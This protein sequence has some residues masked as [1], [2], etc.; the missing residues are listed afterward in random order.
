MSLAD[1]PGAVRNP[2][3]SVPSAYDW[4]INKG[5]EWCNA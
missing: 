1:T 2:G 4:A 5:R 3:S